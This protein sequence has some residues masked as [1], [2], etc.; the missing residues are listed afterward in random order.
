MGQVRIIGGLWKRSVLRVL[1][2]PGLRPTPDRVRETLFNWI[3]SWAQT[4]LTQSRVCDVF[5]GTGALA[6]EAASRGAA[7]VVA[8]ESD[9]L[10]AKEIAQAAER[11]GAHNLKALK[12]DALSFLARQPAN[13]FDLVFIDPP[14][15]QGLLAQG[16]AAAKAV[17]S[18][19]GMVHVEGERPWRELLS[20]EQQLGWLEQRSAKA[21]AVHHALLSLEPS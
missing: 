16:L 18:P 2:R 9:A 20:P 6:F 13:S 21:G 10:A 15:G 12:T 3:E 5:A 14:F 1:D 8:L 19:Q 4:P 11:L 7:S 17:L